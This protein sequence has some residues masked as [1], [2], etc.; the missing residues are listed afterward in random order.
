VFR[1]RANPS[2][3]DYLCIEGDN[4]FQAIPVALH[5]ENHHVVGEKAR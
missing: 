2:G 3:H 1:V 4:G 5:V